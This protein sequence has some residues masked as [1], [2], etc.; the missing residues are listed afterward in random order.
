MYTV[1]SSSFFVRILNN[2]VFFFF[3][4]RRRHTRCLS[5]WSSDVCSS[6]L[7]ILLHLLL[8]LRRHFHQIGPLIHFALLLADIAKF[9]GSGD[10]LR[11]R[12]RALDL[13]RS[14]KFR[15]FTFGDGVFPMFIQAHEQM[16]IP[17]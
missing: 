3:S 16:P 7:K 14:E 4:S 2:T 6:D 8:E 11:S 9:D 10:H 15:G 13:R 17:G 5:D 12:G 1:F